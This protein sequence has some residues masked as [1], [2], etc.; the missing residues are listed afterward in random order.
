M[1]GENT[2]ATLN[3]LFKAVYASNL[4]DLIPDNVKLCKAVPFITKAK[5]QGLSYNQMVVLGSEHGVTYGGTSGEAF[6][7]AA[8]ISGTTKN[9]TI[10]SAEM[11]LRGKI[12]R[13]AISR[14]KNVSEGAFIE[15]TKHV[16]NNM[17]KSAFIKHET[18]CFYGGVGIASVGSI[19]SSTVLQITLADFA[20]GIWAGSEKMA[21]EFYD[22]TLTTKRTGTATE[23]AISKVDLTNRNLTF[24]AAMPT[25]V[26]VTDVIFEKG[27]YGKEFDGVQKI[28]STTSGTIFGIETSEYSL[29]QGNTYDVSGAL[30][31][32]KVSASVAP[33][34]AK[35][36]SNKLS[37]FIN[38]KAWSNLLTEQ[39]ALRTFHE[40]GVSEYQQGAKTIMFYSQN[41]EIEIIASPFVKE[42]YGFIL[43][44][45]DF[46]RVGS[47]DITFEDPVEKGK[48]MEN[49][50]GSNAIQMI[51]YCDA[52]LFC[53]ALGR[54]IL[55]SGIVNS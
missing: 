27:A 23:V 7:Y 21:L 43:D 32:A 46:E 6:E 53:N 40:G 25:D 54:Q 37:A 12:S 18:Q 4:K 26:V 30:T 49:L 20:P 33:A 17:L 39:T 5:N 13:G 8:A 16:V 55:L 36:V 19:A 2:M 50:E 41:G 24:A 28:I 52:A 14:S 3:G 34:V 31:F 44:L 22:A 1:A 11:V 48:Y 35:G 42:G 38:P 9:A 45:E 15:A 29:W 10:Q 47:S 51:A